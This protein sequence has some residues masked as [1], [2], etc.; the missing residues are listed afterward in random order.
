M[1]FTPE[2]QAIIDHEKGHVLVRAVAGAGKTHT[3][4]A[5]IQKLINKGTEPKHILVVQFNKDAKLSFEAR[6]QKALGD[7]NLPMV[8]TAK[9]KA[10]KP[11]SYSFAS[12]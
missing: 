8:R 11:E 1:P 12:P 2:Q 4:V 3:M 6:L 5:R 7:E 10:Q 9:K